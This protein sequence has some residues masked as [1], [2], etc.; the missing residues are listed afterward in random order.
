MLTGKFVPLRCIEDLELHDPPDWFPLPVEF[1]TGTVELDRRRWLGEKMPPPASNRT[2]IHKS[3]P[4]SCW[5]NYL[6]IITAFLSCIF[7]H[8]ISKHELCRLLTQIIFPCSC[9]CVTDRQ[10]I[11]FCVLLRNDIFCYNKHSCPGCGWFIVRDC[12]LRLCFLFIYP[13]SATAKLN[14]EL[15]CQRHNMQPLQHKS[16]CEFW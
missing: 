1:E 5:I 12:G 11:L 13:H 8:Y 6:K 4:A 9:N 14:V 15:H 7:Q 3:L 2:L 10:L 16:W